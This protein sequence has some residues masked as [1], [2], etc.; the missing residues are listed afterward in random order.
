VTL[1][2]LRLAWVRLAWV[3]RCPGRGWLAVGRRGGVQDGRGR[4]RLR[5]S[6]GRWYWS[7]G[8]GSCRAWRGRPGTGLRRLWRGCRWLAEYGRGLSGWIVGWFAGHDGYGRR[9]SGRWS[10]L[11]VPG[12]RVRRGN[13]AELGR[14]GVGLLRGGRLPGVGLTYWGHW[15]RVRPNGGGSGRVA[16]RQCWWWRRWLVRHV[17]KTSLD[18]LRDGGGP[19]VRRRRTDCRVESRVSL[20][21]R[22]GGLADA[23]ARSVGGGCEAN[24]RRGGWLGGGR[25]CRGHLGCGGLLGRSGQRWRR[26]LGGTGLRW[27]RN[28]GGNGLRWRAG[29]G[30]RGLDRRLGWNGRVDGPTVHV[31]RLG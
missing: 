22:L 29:L 7:R 21:V 30:R 6:L 11:R 19:L 14:P 20:C 8:I 1:F 28:L 23:P 4:A 16:L 26:G 18:G 10:G 17:C 2:R 25:L 15:C 3:R 5:R 9:L 13:L 31:G 27:R 24:W 12:D